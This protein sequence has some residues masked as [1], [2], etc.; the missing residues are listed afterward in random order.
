MSD[1]AEVFRL[2]RECK[3]NAPASPSQISQLRDSVAFDLP[4][5]YL[6]FLRRA[7]GCCG[8]LGKHNWLILD[9]I[10]NA[11]SATRDARLPEFLPDHFLIGSDGGGTGLA[12]YY[13]GLRGQYVKFPFDWMDS[14]QVVPL[15][16]SFT[17]MLRALAAYEPSDKF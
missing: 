17:E 3:L 6:A 16:R 14:T 13:G 4:D 9:D 1:A 5:D 7:N 12:Y 10:S 8:A 15:G 2:L 11:L